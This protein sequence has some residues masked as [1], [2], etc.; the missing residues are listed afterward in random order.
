MIKTGIQIEIFFKFSSK[1]DQTKVQKI[2]H[3]NSQ[4]T[5][6]KRCLINLYRGEKMNSLPRGIDIWFLL[7]NTIYRFAAVRKNIVPT[8]STSLIVLLHIPPIS[9]WFY[10]LNTMVTVY[11][12]VVHP[13]LGN[14]AISCA[15]SFTDCFENTDVAEAC[16]FC[17]NSSNRETTK[18]SPSSASFKSCLPGYKNCNR[19]FT[20]STPSPFSWKWRNSF[21]LFTTLHCNKWS[22]TAIST[23][24]HCRSSC[25]DVP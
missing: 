9:K 16:R 24:S 13:T 22:F 5:Q 19:F 10:G 12:R 21:L 25:S 7:L 2:V 11:K 18:K 17:L 6:N 3:N 14:S 20:L 8:I 1:V 4:T 23:L 15:K